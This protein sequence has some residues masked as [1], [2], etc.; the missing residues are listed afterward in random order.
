[1]PYVCFIVEYAAICGMNAARI[2]EWPCRG[3]EL[4][5]WTRVF[6][7]KK[8]DIQGEGSRRSAEAWN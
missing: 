4:P 6:D 3:G 8:E 5:K 1:M 2:S 7:A